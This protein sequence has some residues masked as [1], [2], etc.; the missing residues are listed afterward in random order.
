MTVKF[1][2]NF[3]STIYVTE[4]DFGRYAQRVFQ[5]ELSLMSRLA[6]MKRAQFVRQATN[7]VLP[8]LRITEE[9]I[10]AVNCSELLSPKIL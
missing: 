5:A 3:H 2:V 8:H 4:L 1:I 6:G 9:N 10:C 7:N